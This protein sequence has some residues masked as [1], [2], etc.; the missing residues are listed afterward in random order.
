M[1]ILEK[2][3]KNKKLYFSINYKN[4]ENYEFYKES[5]LEN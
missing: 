1:I 4:K 3:R 5:S 2:K